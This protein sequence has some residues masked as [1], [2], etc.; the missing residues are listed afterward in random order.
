[1]IHISRVVFAFSV[2]F[3]VISCGGGS[4]SGTDSGA[5]AAFTTTVSA[6][7]AGMMMAGVGD[8]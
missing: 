1:M 4:G 2:I 5:G 7:V 6:A 8:R 3:F